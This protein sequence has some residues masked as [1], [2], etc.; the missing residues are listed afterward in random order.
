M[1]NKQS[2]NILKRWYKLA[3]PNKRAWAGQIITYIIYTTCLFL[4]TIFAAKTINN[5]YNKNWPMAFLNLGIEILLIVIRC[6]A[7]HF[8]YIFYSK[9]HYS[10]KNHV[11]KKIYNKILTIDDKKEKEFTK[12]KITNIALNNMGNLAEFPDAVAIFFGYS[13]QV[14]ITLITVYV[15]NWIAGIIITL[16]GV[17]NFFAYYKFNKKLGEIMRKRHER[18]DDMFKSYTKVLNGKMVINEYHIKDKYEEQVLTDVDKFSKEYSA[19]YKVYSYKAHL[20]YA[21]WNIVVY[22][23]AALM[24]FFVS[25]GTL[26]MAIY[27]IIVPYLTSCTDKLNT[28]FE[29]TSSLENMRV[30]VDRV[31]LILNLD[32]KQ[33]IKYGQL[34]KD[35]QAYNLGLIDVSCDGSDD[36]GNLVNA[37]ISFKMHDI[38]LIKGE[39]GSGKRVV[40]NMLRRTMAPNK[41][42]V[43]LDNLDLFD[44][45]ERTFKNHIDYCASH[46]VFIKGSIKENLLLAKNNFEEVKAI[47]DKLGLTANI[48]RYENGFDTNIDD[49]KSS[50]TLFLIG[51]TRA[52]L[53]DCRILMIYELPQDTPET[54]RKKIVNYLTAYKPEKTIILFSHSDAYDEIAGISYV[55]NKGKVKLEKIKKIKII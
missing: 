16:L 14:I 46:P 22:A 41:G 10:I 40:F 31:N 24:L 28:L 1:K 23:V 4:F 48:E 11:A 25:K 17:V 47:A 38:N 15:S 30:D 42:K 13:I 20:Y 50:G 6:V 39:R 33:L 43:L 5:M 55:V 26:E 21:L 12:E 45:N 29:R 27:L 53:S 49:I 51:L 19:Y 9:Q 7:I 18:T 54:F 37:D 8:E 3:R 34:N 36:S 32:E 2:E 35:S 52:L 44:Y